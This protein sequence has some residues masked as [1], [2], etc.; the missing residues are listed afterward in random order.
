MDIASEVPIMR[1]DDFR[2]ASRTFGGYAAKN[3]INDYPS[4]CVYV[5]DVIV[6]RLQLCEEV[7]SHWQDM[8]DIACDRWPLLT[9]D[10]LYSCWRNLDWRR[11]TV[12]KAAAEKSSQD[13]QNIEAC[14]RQKCS[15]ML[16]MLLKCVLLVFYPC[17]GTTPG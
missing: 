10:S 9:T 6:D 2:H 1:L 15:F 8:L 3:W 13:E 17:K 4:Q 11:D 7:M 16:A 14:K 12:D 5:G